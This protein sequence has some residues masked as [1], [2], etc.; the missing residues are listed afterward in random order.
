MN[1]KKLRMKKSLLMLCIGFIAISSNKVSAQAVE[2][3]NVIID[4][5]YGF[6]DLYKTVFAAAYDGNE[7]VSTGGIG[8]VGIRAEYM[9]S[10]GVGLGVDIAYTSATVTFD[11]TTLDNNF[12]EVTYTDK[13]G[14]RKIGAMATFNYHFVKRSDAVDAYAMV[15]A[16]YRNRS[17][18]YETTEPGYE[19]ESVSGINPVAFR[20]GA[21]M[22]YFF[23]DNIGMN[24]AI[25]FGQG[26]LINGGLSI[27]F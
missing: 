18:F 9:L 3:G 8:P 21:G 1:I 12:N 6:P 14:T 25:G 5:Y 22:R 4:G 23:T 2:E 26:G 13:A 10:D 27:K 24:L 7:N 19:D 11:R 17:Y 20:I 16:G 15:G